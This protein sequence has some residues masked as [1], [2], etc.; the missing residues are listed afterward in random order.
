VTARFYHASYGVLEINHIV[1]VALLPLTVAICQEGASRINFC[2]GSNTYLNECTGGS[3]SGITNTS[4]TATPSGCAGG[5][6]TYAWYRKNSGVISWGLPIG[7]SNTISLLNDQSYEVKC[8][9]TA[10]CGSTGESL[11]KSVVLYSSPINC[12]S[13]GQQ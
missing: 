13:G 11:I 1:N 9:V 8:V 10:S 6:Y 2:N 3:G 4:F 7:S 5:T 12:S